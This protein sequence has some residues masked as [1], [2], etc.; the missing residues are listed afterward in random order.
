[1]QIKVEP[2][3][4]SWKGGE[5]EWERKKR[6]NTKMHGLITELKYSNWNN[7]YRYKEKQSDIYAPTCKLG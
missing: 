2:Y 5:R 1:M 6:G 7:W 3:S 4:Y